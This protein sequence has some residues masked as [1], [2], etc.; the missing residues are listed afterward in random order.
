MI[1]LIDAVRSIDASDEALGLDPDQGSKIVGGRRLIDGRVWPEG[2]GMDLNLDGFIDELTKDGKFIKS[3]SKV[4]SIN[5]RRR[6]ESEREEGLDES[7]YDGTKV[8]ER[9][10]LMRRP[11]NGGRS[12][13]F[14]TEGRNIK[15]DE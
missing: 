6:Q 9:E 12:G 4:Q 11:R 7:E 2:V 10:E 13:Y 3:G 5:E 14:V 1:T 15:Q 8:L